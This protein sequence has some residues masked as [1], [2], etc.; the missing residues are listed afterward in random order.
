L[1]CASTEREITMLKFIQNSRMNDLRLPGLFLGLVALTAVISATP[2]A[3]A[4]AQ[5]PAGLLRLD[6]PQPSN[7]T[8]K[9]ADDQRAK[10]RSAYARTRKPQAQ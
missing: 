7:D 10:V 1:S 6:P 2:V 9:L 4:L 5:V 3:P 8:T